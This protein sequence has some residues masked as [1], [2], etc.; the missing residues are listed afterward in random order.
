M[1]KI[2]KECILWE[3]REIEI[4]DGLRSFGR[5]RSGPQD[6]K[7]F[8]VLLK[9]REIDRRR[10]ANFEHPK[11]HP[12]KRCVWRPRGEREKTA[13]RRRDAGDSQRKVSPRRVQGKQS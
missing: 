1:P 3:D 13:Q 5:K 10:H 6:D 7:R 11:T 12:Q 8:V 9:V 2:G 4:A